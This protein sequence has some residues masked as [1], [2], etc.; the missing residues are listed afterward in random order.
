MLNHPLF[1]ALIIFVMLAVTWLSPVLATKAGE[2]WAKNAD[3]HNQENRIFRFYSFF[4]HRP[5]IAADVRMR[6]RQRFPFCLL[7]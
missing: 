7:E 4:G 6:R 1:I 5:E 2:Y 3:K